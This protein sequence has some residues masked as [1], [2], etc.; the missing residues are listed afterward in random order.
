[1]YLIKK[2]YG[3]KII[4]SPVY[5]HSFRFI[6]PKKI[7][8]VQKFELKFSASEMLTTVSDKL[9]YYRHKKGL[10]QIDVADYL[11]IKRSSY[12]AYEKNQ[13]DYYSPEIMD[14]IAELLEV[15]V[16]NLLDDYNIFM[17]NG[18]GMYIKNLR[19]ELNISQKELAKM[20]G[21]ELCK[22]VRWESESVRMNKH[23][24]EMLINLFRSEI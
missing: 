7:S 1:M 20:M 2:Q 19:N 5:L 3:S 6:T 23:T 8:E 18:Q 21:V 14:K 11:K 22:V 17:Y 16:Y 10:Y 15:D 4:A 9:R 24:W 12:S 13:K